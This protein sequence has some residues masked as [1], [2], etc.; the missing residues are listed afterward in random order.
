M[1]GSDTGPQ[2]IHWVSTHQLPVEAILKHLTWRE[3]VQLAS[4][5][6][7]LW[8]KV[9]WMVT[10]APPDLEA[11][12]D[13]KTP[14]RLRIPLLT[15]L[16]AEQV[17]ADNNKVLRWAC[18]HGQLEV[19]Q[20]LTDRFQLTADDAR[21]ENNEALR[22]A[23]KYGHLEMAQ[24]LT[25]RFQ[26]TAE[27]ARA[28]H[29]EALRMAC[30]Y[31]HLEV[32]QWL[33]DR[34]QLTTKDLWTHHNGVLRWACRH[35]HLAVAQWLTDRFQLTADDARV[36]QNDAFL[37][38]CEYGHLEVASTCKGLWQEVAWNSEYLAETQWLTVRFELTSDDA[39]MFENEAL[40][41]AC[42]YRPF[43]GVPVANGPVPANSGRRPGGRQRGVA[44]GVLLRVFGS[45]PVADGPVPA[46]GGGRPSK[47]QPGAAVC[48]PLRVLESGAMARGPVR[49]FV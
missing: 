30:K 33:T 14:D 9:M 44:D 29:N 35:G 37:W 3:A 32:A 28:H 49:H 10:Q 15:G 42:R 17:R 2:V 34:F 24:W 36:W 7:G 39:R 26:L 47:K 11:A 16:T 40:R 18:K 45:S 8:Q 43:G 38:A 20:W 41:M 21:A 31:G 12:L 25:D 48:V 13:P 5:C 19:A 22:L 27:D 4:T 23:C 46:D 1:V 6:K